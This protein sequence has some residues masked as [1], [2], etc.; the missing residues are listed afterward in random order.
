M[1]I[2]LVNGIKKYSEPQELRENYQVTT[3][4]A[5]LKTYGWDAYNYLRIKT[6]KRHGKLYHLGDRMYI[7]T[8]PPD[9]HDDICRNADYEVILDP[10]ESL[11]FTEIIL[12]KR[13]GK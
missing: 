6:S 4:E 13:S 8:T 2:I 10:K 1:Q 12:R 11:N 7:N 5:D 3:T 9:E